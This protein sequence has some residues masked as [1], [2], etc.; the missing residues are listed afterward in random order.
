[1]N[2]KGL[3]VF[4]LNVILRGDLTHDNQVNMDDIAELSSGWQT[5]YFMDTLLDVAQDWL[6][7]V[8]DPDLVGHWP[9]DETAG[10]TAPDA[11]LYGH[12][13]TLVNTD[14]TDWVAGKTG[15]ALNFDGDNNYVAIENLPLV[16]AGGDVTVSAWM[17]AARNEHRFLSL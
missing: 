10:T 17:K 14:D 12:D 13:G 9:F 16:L 15:N 11:S 6:Y 3:Q 7:G 1:M 4:Q 5:G 2:L 8:P